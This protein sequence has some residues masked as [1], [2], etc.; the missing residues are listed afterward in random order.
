LLGIVRE[1]GGGPDPGGRSY[2]KPTK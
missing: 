1:G 2:L